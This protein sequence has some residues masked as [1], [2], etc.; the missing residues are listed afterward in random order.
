MGLVKFDLHDPYAIYL[1]DTPAKG[2]FDGVERDLSH[3]CVRVEDAVAF[4]RMLAGEAGQTARF[5]TALSSGRTEAIRLGSPI[6]V[7]LLYHTAY[8]DADGVVSIADDIYGRDEGLARAL[9]MA[10]LYG[11]EGAQSA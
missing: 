1:H 11:G 10:P 8:V 5:D 7:R 6:P 2:V 9:G 3:G 4:A